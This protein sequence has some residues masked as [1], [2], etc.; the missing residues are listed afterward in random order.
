MT[1]A[2][3]EAAI[4]PYK[5]L[6]REINDDGLVLQI[7]DEGSHWVECGACDEVSNSYDSIKHLPDCWL[8]RTRALLAEKEKK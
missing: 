6:L 3:L 5:D 7:H 4:K 2:L 8:L 1:H